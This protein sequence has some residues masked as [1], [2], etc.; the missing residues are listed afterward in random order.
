MLSFAIIIFA[1][2]NFAE[3]ELRASMIQVM[4]LGGI[5]SLS[6][7]SFGSLFAALFKTEI[8]FIRASI[9]YPVPAFILSGYTFPIESMPSSMQILAKFFPLTYFSNDMR[10]LFL[11]GDSPNFFEN[12][13]ILTIMSAIFLIGN[14]ISLRIRVK[15]SEITSR[16]DGISLL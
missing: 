1:I 2:E 12:V 4:I 8:D 13:S 11:I 9:L 14:Q 5:F 7:L 15:K 10:D 16:D 3:V 6:V